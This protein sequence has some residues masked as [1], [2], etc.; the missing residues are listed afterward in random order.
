L[1]KVYVPPGGPPQGIAPS[2]EIHG[3]M[4]TENVFRM[5]QD[6]YAELEQSSIRHLFAE[7]MVLA[8]QR[9]A[10]FFVQ[11]LGGP[12]MYNEQYGQPAMRARH[13]PFAIDED[14]RQVWVDCFFTVLERAEKYEFPLEH[15]DG[16][17]TFLD[18]F[19]KW[20]VNRG[21]SDR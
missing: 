2:R 4:G 20:M 19:S 21:P 10:A 7:D 9:S 17:K 13:M 5:L 6:V 18:E 1:D 8:S 14:A 16:F 3:S 11:L 12:P 15:L